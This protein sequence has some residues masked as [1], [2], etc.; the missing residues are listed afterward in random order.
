MQRVVWYP[1]FRCNYDCPYCYEKQYLPQSEERPCKDWINLFKTRNRTLID[2]SGGEPF[3]YPHLTGLIKKLSKRHQVAVTTNL[4]GRVLAMVME[5]QGIKDLSL[6]LSYHP[7]HADW[8]QFLQRAVVINK[9]F[10]HVTVNVVLYPAVLKTARIVLSDMEQMGIKHHA[11]PF[12]YPDR[13]YTP[14]QMRTVQSLAGTNRVLGWQDTGSQTMRKCTAGMDQEHWLPNGDVFVCG[15]YLMLL[16][17]NKIID[18]SEH[19]R[20]NVFDKT[21][22]PLT[23]AIECDIPCVTGCDMDHHADVWGM[24]DKK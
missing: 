9:M 20:G 12:I 17:L 4:S 14:E 2:I 23:E 15:S 18:R 5:L 16:M 8:D 19:Y 3:L 6:T 7:Y 24:R 22:R 10:E 21:Y 11:E 13:P 1:T